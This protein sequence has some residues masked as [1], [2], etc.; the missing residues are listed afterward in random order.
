MSTLRP[1][2]DTVLV[3]NMER[4][5]RQVGSIVI[6]DD[7]DQPRGIR[8]RWAQV[9]KLGPENDELE[10]GQWILIE[11]GRWSRELTIE[12]DDGNELILYQADW[13]EG[14]LAIADEKPED[15]H[16]FSEAIES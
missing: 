1:L 6:P 4:G 9:Y 12:D 10:I 5:E 8:P 13:P 2:R 16:T 7:E 11:H 14:V 3:H 15:I